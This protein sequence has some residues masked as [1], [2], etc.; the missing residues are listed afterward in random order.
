MALV[1]NGTT[2]AFSDSASPRNVIRML[3]LAAEKGVK[4]VRSPF[5]VFLPWSDLGADL[6][7]LAPKYLEDRPGCSMA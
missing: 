2:I 5:R 3:E 1:L 6:Q 7:E 4:A